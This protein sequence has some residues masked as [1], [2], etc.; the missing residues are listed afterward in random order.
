MVTVYV[1]EHAGVATVSVYKDGQ[2][3]QR[4]DV[5][6]DKLTNAGVSDLRTRHR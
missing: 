4:E 5:P 6:W 3:V 1:Q 2:L